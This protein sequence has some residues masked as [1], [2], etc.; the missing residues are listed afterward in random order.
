VRDLGRDL[1]VILRQLRRAPAF[2]LLAILTLGLGIGV[3][4]AVFEVMDALLLR[5]AGALNLKDVFMVDLVARRVAPGTPTFTNPS[6]VQFEALEAQPP[7][8]VDAVAAAHTRV[9]AI[10]APGRA[11]RVVAEIA[12]GGFSR[13]FRLQAQ[14]G[15]FLGPEDDRA[16]AATAVVSERLW[17]EWF[18]GRRDL[19]GRATLVVDDRSLTVVGVAPHDYRGLSPVVRTEIW[20]SLRSIDNQ[21]PGRGPGRTSPMIAGQIFVRTTPGTPRAALEGTLL[22]ALEHGPDP[23]GHE[24]F[25][26]LVHA[27]TGRIGAGLFR[28]AG[29]LMLSL[30]AL[31]LVAACANFGNMLYTRVQQRSGEIAVRLAHGAS[32]GRILRLVA[33][34]AGLLC[35][36]GAA[37]GMAGAI[38]ATP[39]VRAGVTRM[40]AGGRQTAWPGLSIELAAGGRV[41]LYALLAAALGIVLVGIPAAWH[42][43][44]QTSRAALTAEGLAGLTP[45]GA[46]LRLALVSIQVS[47][48]VLLLLTV[49]VYLQQL[50]RLLPTRVLFDTSHVTA[51]RLDLSLQGYTESRGRAFYM[52]VL[53]AARHLP[54]V[55][56]AALTDG[57]PGYAYVS[58][59]LFT[60]VPEQGAS[61]V[62]DVAHRIDGAYAGISPDFFDTLGM[63]IVRGRGLNAADGS[64]APLVAVLCERAAERLW[65]GADAIGKRVKFGS[66]REWRTVVGLSSDPARST[67]DT[68]WHCEA[69]VAFVP[70]E[71]R[72]RP[73][74]LIMVRSAAPPA[75]VE[76]LRAAIRSLDPAI[77][78]L[79]AAPLETSLLAAV[80]P[81]R[82]AM[83]S[84]ATLGASALAIAAFGVYGV[85]AYLVSRRR[86]EFGIRLALGASPGQLIRGVVDEAI[87]ITLIGLVPGV[88]IAATGMRLFER[89][90]HGFVPDDIPSW[91]AIP[92]IVLAVAIVAAW[93]PARRAA[94]VDPNVALRDL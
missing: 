71:Q 62:P 50:G 28:P 22:N 35:L 1:R 93:V 37:L 85:L 25:G 76:P 61:G 47:A 40:M 78:I 30:A 34:E 29:L 88:F 60:L 64:G 4:I 39:V 89:Q 24:E 59:G 52:H 56:S 57:L 54:G 72:Y 41:V 94:A 80:R 51:A 91:F 65:P 84:V 45:R 8:G 92:G 46:R 68:P 20:L 87:H 12:T 5:P 77:A 63:R 23:A 21:R 86:R 13:V 31:L 79:E 33:M 27:A 67:G 15:R 73:E 74:M 81:T 11:E 3:N 44:R 75:Q 49:S 32:R 18:G 6:V 19:I 17:R 53:D 42:A 82:A 10:R 2:T 66:E 14:A 38:A 16:G 83:A 90:L 55:Q 43:S 7:E 70:W 9:V 36:A 58:A 69:C 26:V 48:A